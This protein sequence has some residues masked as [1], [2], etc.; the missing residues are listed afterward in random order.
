MPKRYNNTIRKL[1][2]KNKKTIKAILISIT[3]IRLII[4]IKDP[5]EALSV[6]CIYIKEDTEVK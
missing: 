4:C 5:K 2:L 3:R 1:F 6:D